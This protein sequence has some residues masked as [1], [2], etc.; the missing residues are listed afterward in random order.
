ME[1]AEEQERLLQ[2]S[3]AELDERRRR[4]DQLR[5]ALEAREAERI[6]IEEKYSSLQV[7]LSRLLAE[8][9][10]CPGLAEW[11]ICKNCIKMFL[12]FRN[13]CRRKPLGKQRS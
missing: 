10:F 3:A 2:E 12:L 4:E 6:D 8:L 1:K 9:L 11:L 5:K 13:I 7:G